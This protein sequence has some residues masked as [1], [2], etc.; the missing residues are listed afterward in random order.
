MLACRSGFMPHSLFVSNVSV[1]T[2][3][4]TKKLN[5]LFLLGKDNSEIIEQM[6]NITIRSETNYDELF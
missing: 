2:D 6:I 3:I 1:L 4:A 5:K